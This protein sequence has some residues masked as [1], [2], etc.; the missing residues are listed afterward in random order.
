IPA[1]TFASR[2]K[3]TLKPKLAK[4]CVL[5][6]AFRCAPRANNETPFWTEPLSVCPSMVLLISKFRFAKQTVSVSL[7]QGVIR[8]LFRATFG[9]FFHQDTQIPLPIDLSNRY[10]FGFQ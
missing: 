3:P 8:S 2:T 6:I 9:V 4:E 5:P 10:L 1:H 7:I